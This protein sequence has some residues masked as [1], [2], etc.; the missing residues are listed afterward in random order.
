M[1]V[2]AVV[3][4]KGG[5]GKTT[6]SIYL[7]MAAAR[8]GLRVRVIDMD[9]QGTASDWFFL[10]KEDGQGLPFEVQTMNVVAL[11]RGLADKGVDVA[12][13][14]T[15]PGQGAIIDAAIDAANFV[16]V[17]SGVG[18]AD[19]WRTVATSEVM[20]DIPWRV[21]VVRA[22]KNTVALRETL[23]YLD[24]SSVPRF[25]SVIPTRQEIVRAPGTTPTNLHGYEDVWDELKGELK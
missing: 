24:E 21:L 11:S 17:A 8:E 13:I 9:M 25:A 20:G 14:D 15:P 18:G 7:A 3:N 5:V 12:F 6:S 2:V 4:T 19:M 16:V 1:T 23:A 22:E 10:A